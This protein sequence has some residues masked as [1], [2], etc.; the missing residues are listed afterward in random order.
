MFPTLKL[1]LHG[2]SKFFIFFIVLYIFL[3]SPP[4]YDNNLYL[5]SFPSFL[6]SDYV[7]IFLIHRLI[8]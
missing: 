7:F 1:A 5:I 2:I 3:C 6:N 8:D 4:S